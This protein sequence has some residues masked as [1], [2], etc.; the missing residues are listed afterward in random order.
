MNPE[1]LQLAI[2]EWKEKYESIF[3]VSLFD[4]E[5]EFVHVFIFRSL[6]REEY[7]RITYSETDQGEHQE[8]VCKH[9]VLYPENYDFTK[10]LAGIAEVLS[11]QIIDVSGVIPGQAKPLLD[12][13]REELLVFDY[14]A[15]CLIHEAFPEY[16]LDEIQS[17]S[18]R[19]TMYYLSRAEYIL[20][21]LRGIPLVPLD[22]APQAAE[23]DQKFN[24]NFVSSRQDRP[25]EPPMIPADGELSEA[26]VM[27]MIARNEAEQGRN[28]NP[29]VNDLAKESFPELGWFAFEDELKGTFD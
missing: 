29:K 7:K 9:A 10:G 24:N 28:M 6:G 2:L 1:E 5:K 11:E 23:Q 14:V 13:F 20:R 8:A 27:A 22:E 21:E 16:T 25:D 12:Q 26:E 4:V 19:K 18:V 3:Q 15:D 17:W